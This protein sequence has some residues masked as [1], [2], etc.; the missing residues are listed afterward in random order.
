MTKWK[1]TIFTLNDSSKFSP[2]QTRRPG[3][4]APNSKKYSLLIANKP[5]ACVGDLSN[6]TNNNDNYKKLTK[7]QGKTK[8]NT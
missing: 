3:S 5:P 6:K 8:H 1:Y 2:P 4:Y 7:N